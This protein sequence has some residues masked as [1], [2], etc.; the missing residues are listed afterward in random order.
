M[1]GIYG[2]SEDFFSTVIIL[3][4]PSPSMN[5]TNHSGW[6]FL[7]GTSDLITGTKSGYNYFKFSDIP[8]F[9]EYLRLRIF[10]NPCSLK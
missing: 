5:P 4:L 10:I 7:S 1:L 8:L 3:K 6:I 2:A 9:R